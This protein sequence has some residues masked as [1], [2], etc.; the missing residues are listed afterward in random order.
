MK[1][2]YHPQKS[3]TRWNCGTG[4][5][6]TTGTFRLLRIS[7]F[8]TAVDSDAAAAEDGRRAGHKYTLFTTFILKSY[9][10]VMFLTLTHR[11]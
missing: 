7:C 6:G 10:K 5:T 9:S 11:G 4:T 2:L 8:R 1:Y 3:G